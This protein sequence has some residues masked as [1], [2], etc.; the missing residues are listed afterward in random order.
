MEICLVGVAALLAFVWLCLALLG[1]VRILAVGSSMIS[2]PDRQC[3]GDRPGTA[4]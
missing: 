1:F 2:G 4:P 3:A